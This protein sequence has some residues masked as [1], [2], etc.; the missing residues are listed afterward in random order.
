MTKI[1]AECAVSSCTVIKLHPDRHGSDWVKWVSQLLMFSPSRTLKKGLS[2]SWF[3]QLHHFI[4]SISLD[5]SPHSVVLISHIPY[6][7]PIWSTQLLSFVT[8]ASTWTW[9]H[10]PEDGGRPLCRWKGI[11][12]DLIK[13]GVGV[14]TDSRNS[15]HS[16]LAGFWED[17]YEH[18]GSIERVFLEK[19]NDYQLLNEDSAPC[20]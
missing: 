9:S 4:V 1:S 10:H 11:K 6:N 5:P 13:N 14:W 18:T 7:R 2:L 16:P 19:L 12:K 20:S 15:G 8:S 17:G 3:S